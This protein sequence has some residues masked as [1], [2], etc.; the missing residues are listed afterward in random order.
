MKNFKQLLLVLAMAAILTLVGCKG[1]EGP[2]E[3]TGKTLD[4]AAENTGEALKG[5]A[6]KTGEV[7]KDT[8]NAVKGAAKKTGEAVGS[9]GK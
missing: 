3:K 7:A 2:F 1:S 6:E 8:G 5:A 9:I 4:T